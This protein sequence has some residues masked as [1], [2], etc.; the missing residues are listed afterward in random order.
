MEGSVK[1]TSVFGNLDLD[2]VADDPFLVAS[3]TYRCVVVDSKMVEKDGETTWNWEWKVDEPGN[4]YHNMSIRE[5]YGVWPELTSWNDYSAEQK[6]TTKF[7][8]KRLREAFDF[9]VAE[10]NTVTP[11]MLIGKM[12]YVTTTVNP[13]K[14]EGDERKFTNVKTALC[15]R[16]FIE[17]GGVPGDAA[18]AATGASL[19]I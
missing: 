15:E 18:S 3:S 6:R 4:E 9:T 10:L 16:L 19:G 7:L 2:E 14:K 8:K 1:M 5:R 13:S 11:D 17:R 12:A